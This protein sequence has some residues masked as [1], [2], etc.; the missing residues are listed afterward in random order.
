MICTSTRISARGV[1]CISTS[2]CTSGI[3]DALARAVML[4]FVLFGKT[5]GA[6]A[7]C[8]PG[9]RRMLF[10]NA[11]ISAESECDR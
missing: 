7:C 2:R 9:M 5:V 11:E 3:I 8:A 6:C 10:T 4:L 1:S